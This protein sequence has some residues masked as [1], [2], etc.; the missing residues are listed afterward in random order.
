MAG[1]ACRAKELGF[2]FFLIRQEM[3]PQRNIR[4]QKRKVIC[5]SQVQGAGVLDLMGGLTLGV[6]VSEGFRAPGWGCGV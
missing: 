2:Y 1:R 6:G 5:R 4:D 3:I